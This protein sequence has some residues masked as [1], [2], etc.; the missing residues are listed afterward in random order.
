MAPD[1]K[2]KW[3][4]ECEQDVLPV[5]C[6]GEGLTECVYEGLTGQLAGGA[7][8]VRMCV[9]GARPRPPLYFTLIENLGCAAL[10]A[11]WLLKGHLSVVLV[12]VL[13]VL[14]SLLGVPGA[15]LRFGPCA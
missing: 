10:R 9:C 13:V 1:E 12:L 14:L 7:R 2:G 8:P 3:Q 11:V 6:V 15:C 5:A 4:C